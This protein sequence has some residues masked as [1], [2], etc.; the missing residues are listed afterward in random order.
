M[1]TIWQ[2]LLYINGVEFNGRVSRWT[3]AI[4]MGVDLLDG[5]DASADMDVQMQTSGLSDGEIAAS[6]FPLRSKNLIVEGYVYARTRAYAEELWDQINLTAFPLNTDIELTRY[7][8]IPK[9]VTVR[10]AGQILKSPTEEQGYRWHVPLVQPDPLKYGLDEISDTTGIAGAA[11]GGRTYPRLYPLVYNYIAQGSSNQAE[12][13]LLGTARSAPMITLRGPIPAG[14]RIVLQ[15]TGESLAFDVAL[16]SGDQLVLDAAKETALLN[17][18][19]INSAIIGDWWK[20][21]PSAR[22]IIKLFGEYDPA[23]R[24]T[25][26]ARSAWRN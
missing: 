7:E 2:D 12:L 17:G 16:G 8:G 23:A 3:G 15:N 24:M 14:W 25:V 22:N 1:S 19:N 13:H 18:Y 4:R 9:S 20:L 21:L 10:V 6:R 11:I 5:W 26:S